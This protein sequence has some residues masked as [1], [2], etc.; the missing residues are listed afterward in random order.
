MAQIAGPKPTASFFARMGVPIDGV[1]R[2][3]MAQLEHGNATANVPQNVYD[4][5]NF[6]FNG[7][8]QLDRQAKGLNGAPEWPQLQAMLPE[9]QGTRVL[10]LGCGM[11]WFARWARENGAAYVRGVDL[12]EK[13]L[14]KA[15]IMTTMDN[16]E[17][18]RGHLD[19]LQLPEGE[20]DLVFSSLTFHYLMKL[21]TLIGEIQKSLRPG[22]RLVF[23]IEH[24]I[25]TGPIR[26]G[27]KTDDEGKKYWPLD[28]Y[29]KEGLRLRRWFVGGV[30]KH[31]RTLETYIT[32]LLKNG[33]ELADFVD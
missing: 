20:Y 16:I 7:Y 28:A 1:L 30:R 8:I 4:V 29:Q 26:G 5:D 13:T 14:D 21:P 31:H 22:G 19:E 25:F 2:T 24:P 15:R 33:M 17:Y 3:D 32:L 10:D 6:F 23:S 18:E 27:F 9:L 12:S 11:G